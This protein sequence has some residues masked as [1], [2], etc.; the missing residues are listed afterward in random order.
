MQERG[1]KSNKGE[2]E[3]EKIIKIMAS[4]RELKSKQW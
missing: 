4:R 2:R 3:R 1:K